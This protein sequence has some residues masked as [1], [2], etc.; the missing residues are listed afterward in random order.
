MRRTKD[1]IFQNRDSLEI[2]EY[3]NDYKVLFE[4]IEEK[5]TPDHCIEACKAL[6]E[7]LAKTIVSQVDI[8]N[9]EAQKR[10]DPQDW[11]NFEALKKKMPNNAKFQDLVRQSILVLA[12]YHHSCEK[13]FLLGFCSKYF[14]AIAKLRDKRGDVSH[15]RAAPKLEKSSKGLA[16][17]IESIT[18]VITLHMLEVFTLIDFSIDALPNTSNEIVESFAIKSESDLQKIGQ[19][20][21]LIRDFNA[22]L[23]LENPLTEG[24]SFSEALYY[25]KQEDYLI[26]L[27]DYE[28]E[29]QTE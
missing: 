25:Q 12:A 24:L 9:Q 20:E 14:T 1:F 10:F 22:S 4:A 19:R 5:I 8:S 29:N 18:D 27:S 16:E 28:Y 13:E 17:I 23:D 26:K 7:G 11:K 6:L 15:G 3:L 21:R 2:Y